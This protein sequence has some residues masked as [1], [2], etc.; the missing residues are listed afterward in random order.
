MRKVTIIILI[1]LLC[2]LCVIIFNNNV[3]AEELRPIIIT[4]N[5]SVEG[6][7]KIQ[8]TGSIYYLTGDIEF[9][10][11]SGPFLAAITI[12]KDQIILD[13]KGFKLQNFGNYVGAAIDLAERYN[14]TVKN[15]QIIGFSKGINF[16]KESNELKDSS[17][18][19]VVDNIL[20]AP[21]S[22]G[23][24]V[25]IWVAV[26]TNNK[27]I[28]NKISGY[29][30]F[31][32]LVYFSNETYLSGNEV[33]GNNVGISLDFR[34]EN[35]V[36]RNNQMYDNEKNFEINYVYPSGFVQDID[37]SNTVNS[38]PIIYWINQHNKTVPS[39]AGFVAL[40]NCSEITVQNLNIKNNENGIILYSTNNSA[41]KDNHLDNCGNAIEIRACQNLTVSDNIIYGSSHSGVRISE[42]SDI[43]IIENSI[44]SSSFGI[45]LSGYNN[46]H[47]GYG[48]SNNVSI[49]HN[50]FTG[51]NPAIDI[52][53]STDNVISGNIFKNNP[54]CIR[55]VATTSNLIVGN[56]FTENRGS[57]IYLSEAR[58]NIFY[59]NNFINN[60][61]EIP[62][63]SWYG[64]SGGQNSWD[65][66]YEGNYWS[67]YNGT[68]SNG[69]GI[70]DTPY[71][72]NEENQD[73]YPLMQPKTIPEFSS[74]TILLI[75]ISSSLVFLIINNKLRKR[76]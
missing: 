52:T 34:C 15:F 55:A 45:T 41:I 23:F 67:N 31:G 14:V 64:K 53:F 6:T 72:I 36:L 43:Q 35:T 16:N 70:G 62:Q 27:V 20:T 12:Q 56:H 17:Y 19:T 7:N 9:T 18:N 21:S 33:T 30:Q 3:K 4:S 11:G 5:G 57:A 54:L 71:V 51:N 47:A 8:R 75:L 28:N 42:S 58:N 22:D 74:W 38:K 39:D 61:A 2:N 26:S 1:L 44:D 50:N 59:H 25:G 13:G 46:D 24:N 40:G 48:G 63:I 49:L 32:I 73:N 66:G 60:S 29:N 65:N 68:D 69:D 10:E 76:E 37:T